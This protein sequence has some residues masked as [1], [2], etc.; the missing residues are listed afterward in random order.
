M[1]INKTS[2]CGSSNRLTKKTC[3]K[4]QGKCR[5]VPSFRLSYV[6]IYSCEEH[7]ERA[8]DE[9]IDQQEIAPLFEKLEKVGCSLACQYCQRQAIYVV[10][11][12]CSDTSC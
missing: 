2:R 9:V 4:E 5:P 1:E 3:I 8:L 7:I 10:S 6:E 12:E 11:N